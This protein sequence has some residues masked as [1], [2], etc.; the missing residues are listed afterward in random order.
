MTL[1]ENAKKYE[2]YADALQYILLTV[3]VVTTLL[4]ILYGFEAAAKAKAAALVESGDA[5]RLSEDLTGTLDLASGDLPE[6]LSDSSAL[7]LVMVLLPIFASLLGTIRSKVRPREKW[8]TCLMAA[9]QIV[10]QIYKYRLRTEAYDPTPP[11]STGDDDEP[12]E[13]VRT[14]A[15]RPCHAHCPAPYLCGPF[16]SRDRVR[17]V[18]GCRRSLLR[19]GL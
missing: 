7:G 4:A 13:E 10:D 12:K 17:I 19:C 16:R 18:R 14:P 5:R 9:Y 15:L 6:P 1:M 2:M 3:S 8:G 11:P